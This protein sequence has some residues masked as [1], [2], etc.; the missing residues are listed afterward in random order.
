M[1]D[2]ITLT[3][4][5]P[6]RPYTTHSHIHTG[7]LVITTKLSQTQPLAESAARLMLLGLYNS[8]S[9]W[10]TTSLEEMIY[11]IS[12]SMYDDSPSVR[13]LDFLGIQLFVLHN[14]DT[15]SFPLSNF[16]FLRYNKQPQQLI[17]VNGL[18]V[19]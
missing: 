16:R 14:T 11:R 1:T 3:I 5:H 19:L 13:G 8:T 15:V 6:P 17:R 18:L 12:I 10:L 4:S 9:K 7:Q 2:G